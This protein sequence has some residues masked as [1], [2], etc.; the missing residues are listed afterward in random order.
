[1]IIGFTGKRGVGKSEAARAL[2]ERGFVRAHA[3][4]PGKAATVAYFIYAGADA[5]TAHRMVH[6]D[7]R[8]T[9]SP[10]LPKSHTPRYFMEKFGEFL[11]RQMGPE[12][13]AGI[14]LKKIERENPGASIVCESVV[15]EAEVMRRAGA[16]IARITRPGHK[17]PSG[18][19]T[20]DAQEKVDADIT[21]VNDGSTDDLRRKVGLLAA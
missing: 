4:G 16:K 3:F 11:G 6:G 19:K 2:T 20:D 18:L 9:P 14:E 8:D 15:Y 5:D 1:M 13:T 7:L 12:W 21:I 17:G 10:L